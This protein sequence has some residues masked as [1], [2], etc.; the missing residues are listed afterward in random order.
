M[1][2]RTPWTPPP[3]PV[4]FSVVIDETGLLGAHLKCLQ[5]EGGAQ[6]V[7][8]WPSFLCQKCSPEVGSDG[9]RPCDSQGGDLCAQRRVGV[10]RVSVLSMTVPP[11]L[12]FVPDAMGPG[13]MPRGPAAG[14]AFPIHPV[15]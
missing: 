5:V 8:V 14:V 9:R 4:D 10:R 12:L 15:F 1:I 11:A 2:G 7:T 13:L 6:V 3:A